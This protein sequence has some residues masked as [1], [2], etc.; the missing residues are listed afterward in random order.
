M[1]TPLLNTT[2]Y[3]NRSQ[4]WRDSSTGRFISEDRVNQEM[5]AL[6]EKTYSTLESL[7][8]SL[9]AGNIDLAQWQIGVAS[10]LKD[11][12]LAQAMFGAGGR[13][14]MGNVEWGRVGQT[15]REQYGYLDKFAQDIAS[16]NV[17]EAMALSRIDHYGDSSRQSYWNEYVEHS[18]GLLDWHLGATEKHCGRCPEIAAGG[19]YTKETIPSM[20]GDGSTPCLGHCDCTVTRR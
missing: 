6:T 2:S 4:R 12:H 5:F 20:P 8:R 15:L 18:D 13:A 9:Y 3:D 11:A 10:E 19:P 7:T 17:S 1:T 14:N 16:G